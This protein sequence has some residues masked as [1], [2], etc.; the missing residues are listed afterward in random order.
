MAGTRKLRD[1]TAAQGVDSAPLAATGF[2][3]PYAF[4]EAVVGQAIG[5]AAVAW[6][7][8]MLEDVMRTPYK[9]L[10]DPM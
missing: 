10:F 5:W 1:T 9:Q 3:K 8:R 2:V 6:P 7:E 4:A